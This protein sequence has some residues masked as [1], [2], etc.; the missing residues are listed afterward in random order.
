[1]T[2]RQVFSV[3]AE[4]YVKAYSRQHAVESVMRLL[5]TF[6]ANHDSVPRVAVGLAREPEPV[7]LEDMA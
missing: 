1:M 6:E 4:V 3:E 5:R 7:E 2:K